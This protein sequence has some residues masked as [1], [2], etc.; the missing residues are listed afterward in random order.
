MKA[1]LRRGFHFAL[2]VG[3]GV[4]WITLFLFLPSLL[5]ALL[6]FMTNDP[7]GQP[8]LPLTVHAFT[9]VAGYS[10]LG[11]SPGNLEVVWR[12]LLQAAYTT[13]ATALLA[14]PL[15][16]FIARAPVRYRPVL[17]LLVI[18]PSWTN[19][20]VRTYAWMQILAPDTWLSHVAVALGFLPQHMGLYPSSFAVSMGLVYNYLPYMVLPIYASVEKLDW[21]LVDAVRDLYASGWRVFRHGVFPQTVPGLLAG[22]ILVA[23][24]AFGAYIVP[25]LLGGDRAMLLGNLIAQQ[26]SSM[27]DWPFG[28]ALTLVMLLFT[29]GGLVVFRRMARRLNAGEANLL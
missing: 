9:Q 12:S 20:V 22:I 3:P 17:L 28:A 7:Y 8:A 5:M 18:V 24:P 29:F 15:A 1:V 10:F 21:R 16:F 23:I 14:Y 25:Q 4:A 26:F 2:T 27:P 11:W 13:V 6:A 19:Q